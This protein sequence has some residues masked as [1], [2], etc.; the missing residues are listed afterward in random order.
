MIINNSIRTYAPIAPPYFDGCLFMNAT[1]EMPEELAN[2]FTKGL[3]SLSKYLYEKNIDPTKLFPVSLIFTKDGSFSVTE[4]EATTYGRCM[5]FLV[6]SME[7]I[8]TSNNQ[9]MQLFAF[10]ALLFSRNKWNKS[11]TNYFFCCSENIPRNNF[12]GGNIM[13]SKLELMFISKEKSQI[14]DS[15]VIRGITCDTYKTYLQNSSKEQKTIQSP[16][17]S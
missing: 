17:L 2:L 9:H 16:A 3:E 5:S 6:Y 10:S 15:P 8:I 13:G 11:Q 12:R 14:I 4:N 7:R 1:Y